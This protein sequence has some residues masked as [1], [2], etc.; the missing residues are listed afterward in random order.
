MEIRQSKPSDLSQLIE[1]LNELT[2]VGNPQNIPDMVFEN[3]YVAIIDD[4][5]IGCATIL[6][7][8]KIIHGGSSVGHIEDVAVHHSF[9]NQ[10]V[11]KSLIDHCVN[12][13]KERK[14]Y[15][16]IL[17]CSDHNV[18]FYEKCQFKTHGVCMRL[19]L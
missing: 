4:K 19:D 11:G 17:D 5:I 9:R 6:I 10:G 1:I 7:E 13:A 14:C 12:I 2:K 3:I 16:V 18:K 15:K 8:N